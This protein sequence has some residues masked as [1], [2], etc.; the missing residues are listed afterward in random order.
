ME[1]YERK[2][3]GEL[4]RPKAVRGWCY[5]AH[6]GPWGPAAEWAKSSPRNTKVRSSLAEAIV[7]YL[8]EL[9]LGSHPAAAKAYMPPVYKI[10]T[11]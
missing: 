11:S 7:A 8:Y 2:G 3:T 10:A 9:R 5:N 6:R 1:S 4:Q